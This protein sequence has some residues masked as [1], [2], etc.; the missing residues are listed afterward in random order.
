MTG[1]A[2]RSREAQDYVDGVAAELADLPDEERAD[3]L[4]ELASHV[5]ELAAEGD[6]PLVTRLGTPSQYAAELRASAGLPP[7]GARDRTGQQVRER[8]NRVQENRRVRAARD[9]L[10]SLRPAWWVLRAWVVVGLVAMWPGQT[11]PAWADAMPVVP[12]VGTPLVGLLVL[13]VVVVVSVQVGRRARSLSAGRRLGVQV[14]NVGAALMLL[15]VL[16]S[17]GEGSHP[18]YV[19][20]DREPVTVVPHEGVY[21]KGAQVWNIYAYDDAGRLL[22]DVRLFTQDGTPLSLGLRP[23]GTRK[24]VVDQQ[25][26]LVDNA[27]PYRYVEADGTVA[28][29]DAGPQVEA[30]PLLGAPAVTATPTPTPTPTPKAR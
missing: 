13:V 23:D 14:V 9:F 4:D 8:L 18:S 12:R 22:H 2:M 10:G 21:A 5:D 1:T 6:A 7:A 27:Y 17:V 24:P 3:L 16:V 20:V 25:G 26:R 30:P 28:N 11:T 19:Y 29:P 15:P